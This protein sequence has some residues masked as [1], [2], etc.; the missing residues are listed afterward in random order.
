LVTAGDSRSQFQFAIALDC[1]YPT[2]TA[3]ALATAGR[4]SFAKLPGPL[5][6]S[7]GWFLH[8]SA[9]NLLLTHCE[10]LL[11]ERAG[12]RCRLL[13]TEGRDAAATISAFRPF[14]AARITDFRE[15]TKSVL[16]VNEGKVSLDV[17]PH[18]WV[19]FEAE[20]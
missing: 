1:L 5:P 11:G 7:R 19:Q 3:I 10:P 8:I 14:R 2:Q 12:I 4:P 6:T 18:R 9:K 17:G 20:W 13:E 16:S 15:N